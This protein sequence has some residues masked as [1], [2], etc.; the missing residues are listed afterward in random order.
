MP[1]VWKPVSGTDGLYEVSDHG[2]VRS[3]V[4]LKGRQR[5]PIPKLVGYCP[6]KATEYGSA[7]ICYPG[8]RKKNV[9]IHVLVAETFIGPRPPLAEVRHLDGNRHNNRL[10]NLAYGTR[11]QNAEDMVAHGNSPKGDRHG[12]GKLTE[13]QALEILHAP[14][15]QTKAL[16]SKYS[17]SESTIYKIRDPNCYQ[18]NHLR[19]E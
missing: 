4:S 9:H 10:S 11:K 3:Y 6:K 16:A 8:R 7:T 5:L 14:P 1:E 12:R 19:R 2:Q 13:E 18:W 15:G 17:V